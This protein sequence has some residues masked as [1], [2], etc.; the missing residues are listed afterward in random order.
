[1]FAFL[2]FWLPS[3][4]SP[5]LRA[6]RIRGYFNGGLRTFVSG[7]RVFVILFRGFCI[8]SLH[9]CKFLSRFKTLQRLP[10]PWNKKG[11]GDHLNW[12][13]RKGQI[14]WDAVRDGS[15]RF[16]SAPA[17]FGNRA[18]RLAWER[19]GLSKGGMDPGTVTSTFTRGFPKK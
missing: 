18:V 9:F 4:P 6:N 8:P 13:S 3:F 10:P 19:R 14:H 11:D 16:H 12:W 5:S 2:S 15:E 1:M 17:C 7:S